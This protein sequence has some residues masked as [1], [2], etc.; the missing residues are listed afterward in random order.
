MRRQ[1]PPLFLLASLSVI[2]SL[3]GVAASATPANASGA[4]QA[5]S[6]SSGKPI[7]LGVLSDSGQ[8]PLAP[9]IDAANAAAKSINSTGGIHGRPIKIVSCDMK[10][11]PNQ[12]V[13]CANQLINQ[14]VVAF[15]DDGG[16]YAGSAEQIMAKDHVALIGGGSAPQEFA[17]ATTFP[18]SSGAFGA[19]AG[20]GDLA[21]AIG[22]KKVAVAGIQA[23]PLGAL[24]NQGVEAHG[25]KVVAT[26]DIPVGVPDM[27]SYVEAATANGVDTV[28][29]N[30]SPSDFPNFMETLRSFGKN[31]NVVTSADTLDNALTNTRNAS[32]LA[33]VYAAGNYLPAEGSNDP[34]VSQFNHEMNAVG[35]KDRGESEQAVWVA[36]H[37]AA[38]AAEGLKTVTPQSELAQLPMLA[39]LNLGIAPPLSFATR[40]KISALGGMAISVYDPYVVYE[41][42]KNGRISAVNR[43]F[44]KALG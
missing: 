8:Y 7:L 6:T 37:V 16:I 20:E 35:A 41:R 36:V 18:V 14:G 32:D 17:S 9:I 4:G 31:V 24:I 12:S 11:D 33:G 2:L 19:L 5:G 43:N 15:V 38:N 42:F 1:T 28:V 25:G 23:G 44:V 10:G 40:L 26:V 34:R 39:P 21:G 22:G 3:V 30:L 27:S 13:T 29:V